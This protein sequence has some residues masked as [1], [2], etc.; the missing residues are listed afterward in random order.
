VQLSTEAPTLLTK[1]KRGLQ[2]LLFALAGLDLS[3]DPDLAN[4]VSHSG[5]DDT[6]TRNVVLSEHQHKPV[7][8]PVPSGCYQNASEVLR[9]GLRLIEARER[10]EQANLKTL[11]QAVRQGWADVSAGWH[12]DV[13][14]DRLEDFIGQLARRAA[15]RTKTAS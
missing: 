7:A 6:P 3:K 5:A 2:S 11:G 4:L 1:D 12:A 8:T 10:I 9:A 15:R 14:A 13:A